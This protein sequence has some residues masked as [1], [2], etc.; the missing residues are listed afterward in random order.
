MTDFENELTAHVDGLT[1]P[2]LP[3]YDDVVARRARRRTRRRAV[4]GVVGS[5]AVVA[6]IIVGASSLRP[7]GNAEEPPVTA[8]DSSPTSPVIDEIIRDVAPEW[9]EQGA[10]PIV[11][12]L[13]GRQVALEPWT[14][15]YGNMCS[16]GMPVPPFEDAGDRDVVSF[17]FP[18]ED[19]TFE[20]TFTPSAEG[21]CERAI[22]VPVEKMGDFI[23]SI[24]AAGPPGAYDVN[25]FGRG[26][27][28]DVV[29]TFAW[30]TS[31]SGVAP[32]PSG[33]VGLVS[34]DGDRTIA[35]PLELGLK[36]LA[37]TPR[38]ATA[39]VTVT[40]ANGAVKEY[41]PFTPEKGCSGEGQVFFREGGN[42][43][44]AAFDL[45]PAP[46]DYRVEVTL[47]GTTYVGSAVWPRDED[48]EQAPYTTLTFDPPLPAYTG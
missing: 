46:Y 34:D 38:S 10:P 31:V 41:G 8:P 5:A 23:F 20:A 1:P 37:T 48:P 3:P 15:C 24:P 12:H 7:D 44:G 39:T 17:A 6:A 45:G 47:D 4:V 2:V 42:G 30:A 14:S 43:G 13:D 26:P 21:D 9:D 33:Y 32:E 22:T 29:T 35:Y 36:D 19:W 11:L 40:A 28:G 25:V 18:L 27:G 16:D